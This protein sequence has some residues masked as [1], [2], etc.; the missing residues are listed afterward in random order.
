MLNTWQ[1]SFY[2]AQ[3]NKGLIQESTAATTSISVC[4]GRHIA[5]GQW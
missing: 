2:M 5:K 3:R 4:S 1:V